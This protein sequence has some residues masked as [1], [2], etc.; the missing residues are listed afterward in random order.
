V[1]VL[2]RSASRTRTQD[3]YLSDNEQKGLIIFRCGNVVCEVKRALDE[4]DFG[5]AT[6]ILIKWLPR[7][8][9]DTR[10]MADHW[11]ACMRAISLKPFIDNGEGWLTYDDVKN[12]Y[13]AFIF[14]EKSV[15]SDK[16]MIGEKVMT[17]ALHKRHHLWKTKECRYGAKCNFEGR[18]G[19]K[20]AFIHPNEER[21]CKAAK[22]TEEDL[23]QE[24]KDYHEESLRNQAAAATFMSS[25]GQA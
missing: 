4:F 24:L 10:Y 7:V 11:A 19:I 12:I 6:D 13:D 14:F 20:C 8:K 16:V 25:L 22:R 5:K 18:K 17:T 23:E 2:T 3:G 15:Q 9:G 21:V 1:A